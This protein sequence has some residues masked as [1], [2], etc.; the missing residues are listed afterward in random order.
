MMQCDGGGSAEMYVTDRIVNKTTEN[1]P[2]AVANCLMVFDD[3]PADSEISRIEIDYPEEIVSL[4]LEL[5]SRLGFLPIT[6]TIRYLTHYLIILLYVLTALVL[7]MAVDLL[8]PTL[9]HSV[10]LLLFAVRKV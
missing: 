1:T 9:R 3:S 7:S 8:H 6:A 4:P 2:R 5:H 10:R